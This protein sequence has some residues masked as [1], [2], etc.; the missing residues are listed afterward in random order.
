MALAAS[1]A[2]IFGEHKQERPRLQWEEIG[3]EKLDVHRWRA[4]GGE[5]GFIEEPWGPD[6]PKTPV[7]LR[8]HWRRRLLLG[9]FFSIFS[10]YFFLG[11][12]DFG[13]DPRLKWA[14]YYI[15]NV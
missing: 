11:F 13:P 7:L 6:V 1:S 3:R 9:V 5:K 8:I 15:L 14:R 4:L 12:W 2:L 10:L